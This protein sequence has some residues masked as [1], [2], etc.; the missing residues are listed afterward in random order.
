MP[1]SNLGVG[2]VE[3]RQQHRLKY[4]TQDKANDMSTF[5]LLLQ[6]QHEAQDL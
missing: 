3:S 2:G 1:C 4:L 5:A 6:S